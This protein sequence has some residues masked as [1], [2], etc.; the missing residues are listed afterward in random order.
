MP[1]NTEGV[2]RLIDGVVF[3]KEEIDAAVKD[4]VLFAVQYNLGMTPEPSPCQKIVYAIL[5]D[6]GYQ[7]DFEDTESG[8]KLF[9]F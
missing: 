2:Y 9:L 3:S 4:L 8:Q 6:R 7:F 5:K 1:L